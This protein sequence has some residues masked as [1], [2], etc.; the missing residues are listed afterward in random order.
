[1]TAASL[2]TSRAR[3]EVEQRVQ[4]VA[5]AELQV[6]LAGRALFSSSG[7]SPDL[8][9][10]IELDFDARPESPLSDFEKRLA[11]VPAVLA[12]ALTTRA[13]EQLS[14]AQRLTLAPSNTRYF[15]E[16]V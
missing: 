7:V 14:T 9:G 16:A 6:A 13:A 11:S 2:E 8:S 1:G 10:S 3:A 15:A 12:A 5:S 4:Q